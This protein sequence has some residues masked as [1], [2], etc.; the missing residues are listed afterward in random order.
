MPREQFIHGGFRRNVAQPIADHMH[1]STAL[2]LELLNKVNK[3][4][5]RR[6][7]ER[8]PFFLSRDFDL[9]PFQIPG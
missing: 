1:D 5:E 9:T 4:V 7:A 2:L 3:F 6:E 8:T